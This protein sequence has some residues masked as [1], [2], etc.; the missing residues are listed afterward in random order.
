MSTE[1]YWLKANS[2]QIFFWRCCIYEV[3]KEEIYRVTSIIKISN[4]KHWGS[5][6]QKYTKMKLQTQFT[7][8][9]QIWPSPYSYL[10]VVSGNFFYWNDII[11]LENL[12]KIPSLQLNSWSLILCMSIYMSFTFLIRS[13]M[14]CITKIYKIF[15][16]LN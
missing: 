15:K 4:F 12:K 9:S 10:I 1:T 13:L 2:I 5:T 3:S 14:P 16:L 7:A 8:T 6:Y 11:F